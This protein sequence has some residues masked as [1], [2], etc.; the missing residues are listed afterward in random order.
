V[1]RADLFGF[2]TPY[3]A[4]NA[5]LFPAVKQAGF[6]YDC[7]IEEGHQLDQDGTNFFWPYTL[8]G[9]SPGNKSQS[10]RVPITSF[11]PGIWE[12]PAYR[13]LI[14]PDTEAAKYGVPAGTL[15]NIKARNP[16]RIAINEGKITG[17]DYNLFYDFKTTKAE[18]VAILKYTLDLRMKGNRAPLLFGM[19]SK[20]YATADMEPLPQ[21]TVADRRAAV[22]EFLRYAVTIPEVRVVTTKAVLDWI[23]KPV[24]LN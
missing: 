11:P 15:A 23:R 5:A 9:G 3:L 18:F 2:R 8:D 17:L 6:M 21:A 19:H 14:P 4:Y 10:N 20:I 1:K 22:V 12:M 24:A 16:T 13:V 7:S